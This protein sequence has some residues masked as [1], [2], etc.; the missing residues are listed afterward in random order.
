MCPFL[1]CEKGFIESI[2]MENNQS[3]LGTIEDMSILRKRGKP[4][5]R[6]R[7]MSE[8]VVTKELKYVKKLILECLKENPEIEQKLDS[9][10]HQIQVFIFDNCLEQNIVEIIE[11]FLEDHNTNIKVGSTPALAISRKG[12]G[13]IAIFLKNLNEFTKKRADIVNVV[14]YHKNGFF[15]ELCHLVEHKGDSSVHSQSY[16]ALWRRYYSL[17]WL[18]FGNEIIAKLDTNRNHYEV[19]LMMIDAYPNE[20]IERC[21][22]FFAT[23]ILDYSKMIGVPKKIVQAR[24]VVDFLHTIGMRYVIEK[25]PEEQLSE[26]NK[27][28]LH[29]LIN[30]NKERLDTQKK[31]V[32][33]EVGLGAVTLIDS[34]PEEIFQTPTTFFTVILDLWN[35]LRLV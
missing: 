27:K 15:E 35:S 13:C 6:F 2:L 22:K 33:T 16:F 7:N 26:T 17:N 34:L 18:A 28:L 3:N 8:L 23:T 32:E 25:I 24:I 29:K 12:R 11:K 5:L 21:W 1:S 19:Y 30:A 9:F 20:W 4:K 31:L 10:Y 14:A